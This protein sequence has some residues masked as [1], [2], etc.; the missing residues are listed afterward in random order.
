MMKRIFLAAA[1]LAALPLAA[2]AQVEKQV[3]VTKAYVPSLESASKLPLD[4]DLTD[5]VTMR[6]EIDYAITPLSIETTLDVRPIRPATVTYWEFNRPLPCYLKAGAGYP[7]NSVVDFYASTQNPGTGYALGYINHE[8]RYADIRNDFG[9]KNNSVQMRN[10]IGAAAGKYLGKRVLEGAVSYENRL[11]HSYGFTASES[12]DYG[13]ADL[14]LRFG[15]D[16][17]D[18]SRFNFELALEAGLFF[19]HIGY[20]T[21]VGDEKARQA[22][23]GV[24]A[25]LARGFGR[26]RLSLAAGYRLFDGAKSIDDYRE[27]LIH[28]G[29]RYGIDGGVVRLELGADYYHDRIRGAE[30]GDFVIP[31]ARL[32]FD[33]GSAALKPFFEVDG[34][35]RTNDYA[36]LTRLNPYLPAN[37]RLDKPSVDYNGRFGVEGGLGRGRFG[38]R[39]HAGFSIH[40]NHL[41]W[42]GAGIEPTDMPRILLFVAPSQARQTVTSFHA[43][44]TFRPVSAFRM[45]AAG[46]FFIYNNEGDLKSG[47]PTFEGEVT[48]RY[49]G[50]RFSIGA[51]L[52]MRSG[53]EWS[54]LWG[55][56][57]GG[58]DVT[59]TEIYEVPFGLDLR[60]DVEW[61]VSGRVALFAEGRNLVDRR[62]YRYPFF[63][64]YGANFTAGVKLN[65]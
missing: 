50:R 25:R 41:Y 54:L 10:R 22:L 63:P 47:E 59:T 9:V 52:Y 5:T 57:A 55:G 2:R 37:Q 65:F 38:Y 7:L 13:D 26:H 6:P 62:L 3:E 15:D 43:E 45:Q 32:R 40:D 53:R 28:A 44:A 11:Y 33:L 21:V 61:K 42:F 39:V 58:T 24:S 20:S 30:N 31:H 46:H 60:V 56:A 8:G 14:A 19:D 18:L 64:E 36:A 12:Y 49:E 16:F 29:L 27:Q 4:P 34:D 48:A 17:R 1:L 51:G 35:V 23:L